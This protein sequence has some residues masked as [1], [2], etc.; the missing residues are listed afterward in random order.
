MIKSP[1]YGNKSMNV[2]R[3]NSAKVKKEGS[4]VFF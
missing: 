4:C 3:D 1:S 2:I